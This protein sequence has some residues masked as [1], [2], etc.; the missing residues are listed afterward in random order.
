M[1]RRPLI[2]TLF[3]GSSLVLALTGARVMAQDSNE[4]QAPAEKTRVS[5]VD[6]IKALESELIERQSVDSYTSL[7]DG[8]PGARCC[9]FELQFDVGWETTSGEHDPVLFTP[10]LKFTLGGNDFLRNT[11]ITLSAP[12][13]FGLG[14]VKGNADVV[15]G[16]QQRWIAEDGWIP[17]FATLAEVRFPSG[18]HSS[19]IDGT[20]TGIL[21]KDLG[22][23]T[24]YF[25][26]FAET[27]NGHNVDD[28]RHFQ[29]GLRAGYKWRVTDDF[30]LTGCYTH[31]VSEEEHHADLNLLEVS[32]QWEIT[33]NITI[34]PGILIGLDDNEETPNFG[35]GVRLVFSF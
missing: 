29:W 33:E 5:D 3:A 32:G 30:A 21:A 4:T 16:L 10:E 22:P 12:T 13:E 9:S 23:G 31:Q 27:A 24:L 15:L 18:Y 20:L 6:R 17:T 14:R 19:G 28:L 35:A 1:S 8:Q 7:E 2:C 11:Q 25:N 34:G 26:A